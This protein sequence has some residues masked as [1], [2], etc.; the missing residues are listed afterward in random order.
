MP[1]AALPQ[2]RRPRLAPRCQHYGSRRRAEIH[3]RAIDR[4]CPQ[5]DYR[6][7]EVHRRRAKPLPADGGNPR[8][9]DQRGPGARPAVGRER[10]CGTGDHERVTRPGVA[11]PWLWTLFDELHRAGTSAR[12]IART[13]ERCEPA[14]EQL[15][16]DVRGSPQVVP[17]ET[18]WRVGGRTAWLQA[19]VGRRETCYVIDP[20]RS[21]EPAERLLGMDWRARWCMTA[22]AC[23]IDSRRPLIS[24]A[25]AL[26]TAL[27]GTAGNRPRRAPCA[28]RARCWR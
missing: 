3:A 14:Y 4:N 7:F 12:S 8:A 28:C 22:G 2:M 21:D 23:T 6:Q 27:R 10:P 16:H 19:F 17:D 5:V 11:R 1:I 9:F 15:R 26:A 13:A 25:W 24:N 18:G 20:T